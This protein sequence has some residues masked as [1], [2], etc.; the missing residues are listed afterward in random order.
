MPVRPSIKFYYDVVSPYSYIAFHLLRRYRPTWNF[1]L[2][3]VPMF[4]GF[5]LKNVGTPPPAFNPVKVEYMRK[6]IGRIKTIHNIEMNVFPNPFPANTL[7]A[8]RLLHAIKLQGSAEVLEDA[9]VK[10]FASYWTKG[11]DIAS[12]QVLASCVEG[13]EY[14]KAMETQQVKDS[15][16]ALSKEVVEKGVFGAPTMLVD[17]GDGKAEVF[18]GSDRLDHVAWFLGKEVPKAKM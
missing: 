5:T 6:D 2:V 11:E 1:D 13:E 14:L 12:P 18:F 4:L 17:R 15:L 16:V 7:K 10:L 8:M 9:T 3:L